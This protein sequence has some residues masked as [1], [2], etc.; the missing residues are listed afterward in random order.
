MSGEAGAAERAATV[1][2]SAEETGVARHHVPAVGCRHR[3]GAPR[4]AGARRVVEIGALRGETTVLMLDDLGP[5]AELH[6]ID[7]VPGVRPGGARAAV[8][9][10]LRLP[11]RPEPQRAA[12]RCRR[13]TRPSSTATTTGTRSTTSC[14]CCAE[15]ARAAGAPLP[16]LI[17]HDVCWPYGRR[18]LYYDPEHDPGGVPPALRAGGHAARAASAWSTGGGPQPHDVQRRGRGRAPQRRDDRARRLPRRARPAR[19]ACVVLPIYFGLAIVV[20]EER[21]ERAARAGAP[22]STA[23][24]APR[25]AASCWRSPRRSASGRWSSSTTSTTS[26]GGRLERAAR[27]RYLDVVKAALL[28]EHYLENEAAARAPHRPRCQAAQP[29]VPDS[30]ATRS[31]TTRSPYRRLQRERDAARRARRRRSRRRSC[32]T[33]PWAGPSSTT[34]SVPRRGPRR[35]RR[36]RPRRVRHRARRRRHLPARLPRR[37]RARRPH[38]LGGRPLPGLARAPTR[39]P[40]LPERG[41]RRLPGRPQPGAR[42][43]RPLRPARRPG[44]V[45]PGPARRR[46]CPTRPIEQ[47]ALLRIGRTARRRGRDGARPPLRP[48]RRRRLRDRRRGDPDQPRPQVEAFRRSTR[49]ST[50]RS[51]AVDGSAVAWRKTARRPRPAPSAAPDG[52][53]VRR[54][55]ALRSATARRPPTPS[56]S[57]VVVVFYNMRREAARTLHSLSR[58]YQEGIDDLSYEVIV[59]ENGSDARPAPRRGVRAPASGPSSATS[60]SATTPTR[61]RSPPLNHG[62]RAGRGD[63]F[64]LMIDGA[65]VAHARACCASAWPGCEPTRRPS[66]PPSSGTSARASRATPW[67]TATT[68]PT[69]TGSSSG[70]TGRAP[71]TASSRSATS[72]ATATGSTACGRA[73]A[74]SSPRPLLE[75]VGGFDESFSMAGRRLRQPRALRAARLVARRH[76]RH[77]PRRGLVPP[78]PRRHH[79]QPARPDERR[80]RVFGYSRALRRAARAGRSGARASRSTTSAASPSTAAR[81]TKPR[82]LSAEDVRRGGGRRRHRRPADR[83]RSRCPTSCEWAFTEAVGAACRGSST[84][85]LG[86]AGRH[87]RP[88]TCSPT[89]RS[90]PTV[91]PDWVIETGTG[92]GGRALFLASICELSAT[93]RCSRSAPSAGRRPARATRASRYVRRR[94][95]DAGDRR[96]GARRSSATAHAPW[97]SSARCADRRRTT[98]RVRGLRPAR[99][100]RLLRGR[101]PTPSSTATRCGPASGPGPAEAVKQILTRHGEFVADPTL[102]K[103]SLT[104]TPAASSGGSAERRWPPTRSRDGR[105]S[106]VLRSASCTRPLLE[107]VAADARITARRRGERFEFRSRADLALRGAAPRRHQRRVRRPVHLPCQGRRPGHRAI[108][109]SPGCCDRSGA[110]VLGAERHR[111]PGRRQAISR[112]GLPPATCQVVGRRFRHASRPG[113]PSSR[114]SSIDRARRGRHSRAPP[115]GCRAS[116]FGTGVVADRWVR[117]LDSATGHHRRR[118][119]GARRRARRGHR[120]GGARPCAGLGPLPD[121]LDRKRC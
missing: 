31:A 57:R 97:S 107:A 9:R 39:R 48:R 61:R 115:S 75:Q 70:S 20:E 104:S 120:R 118:R 23:S 16:V 53:A 24:R 92:D 19:S 66:S 73:T 106:A 89:R 103:Y 1:P 51:S 78:G 96:R 114:R 93:A 117:G 108:P 102:E 29:L 77:H 54:R 35:G 59:V 67:T 111:R 100:G 82:R 94:A 7:P 4:R 83:A 68:R 36:R 98:A 85:W 72:S 62:I 63:A 17:L 52:R 76:R 113:R 101:R 69:R 18:D 56:T 60:T 64:A 74:C 80:A 26:G 109:V 110:S 33:P 49:A 6:V 43:L 42:R 2:R 3:P 99:A 38:G 71:A 79:H 37:P 21:L 22:R 41:R 55:H 11:P 86:R 81:R 34:S 45:P 95:H 5:E 25:A 50:R 88:P 58:A 65:H 44:P 12:R 28:N 91:R 119:R 47:L 10:P 105:C 46:P 112:T 121:T 90:S 87:R 30:S 40:T 116:T 84:T 15:G 32:P 27:P 13:W 14:S 8:P